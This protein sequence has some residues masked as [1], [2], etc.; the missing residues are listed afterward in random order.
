MEYYAESMLMKFFSYVVARD[1]GFAPNPFHGVCTLA[2]CKPRIRKAANVGDWI[3]GTGSV[4]HQK[5]DNLIYA[6]KV[7]DKI[8]FNEY[9]EDPSFFN[10][11]PVMNGSLKTMYGDN[12]Y[13]SDG[14][15]WHQ[16]NSH[17]SLPDGSPNPL[18]IDN[19]TS[20]TD[21][22]L[23][24][25][26]FYY[27]GREAPEI[28]DPFHSELVKNPRGFHYVSD[29]IGKQFVEYLQEHFEQGYNADPIQFSDQFERYD[30]K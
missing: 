25:N 16:Q 19:D 18:N 11:K 2:T 7:T 10:K 28:L 6:M 27:F 15:V 23:I 14:E 8:S 1:Y 22:V 30:G 3:F 4:K 29:E 12:I 26:E 24:S 9:W 5:H 20:T 13:F 17:H 21:A